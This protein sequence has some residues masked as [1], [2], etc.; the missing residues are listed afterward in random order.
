MNVWAV[1]STPY[2][3]MGLASAQIC[4]CICACMGPVSVPYGAADCKRK[5]ASKI[6]AQLQH[7]STRPAGSALEVVGVGEEA[8]AVLCSP[9]PSGQVI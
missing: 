8:H 2:A 9:L 7:A 5:Q 1:S 3:E 4:I 6:N